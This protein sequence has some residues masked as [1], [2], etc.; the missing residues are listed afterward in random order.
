MGKG[1]GGLVVDTVMDHWKLLVLLVSI[2]GLLILLQSPSAL[3][4]Q[5]NW[6]LWLT[7][8][9]LIFTVFDPTGLINPIGLT[10]LILA[11]TSLVLTVRFVKRKRLTGRLIGRQARARRHRWA[12][13]EEDKDNA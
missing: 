2:A 4:D 3:T 5:I 7:L 10:V 12:I 6:F 11:V 8:T 1:I 13:M 9:A